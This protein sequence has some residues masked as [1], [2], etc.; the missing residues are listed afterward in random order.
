[1]A[2]R[3]F[4]FVLLTSGAVSAV[5]QELYKAPAPSTHTRWASPEN[6]GAAK[7]KAGMS[8]KG[9]KGSAF[10]TLKAGEKLVLLDVKGSGIIHRMWLS[11]TIPRS[12]EQRRLIRIDMY[13]DG[14]TKPAVSAP[15]GDFFGNGLGLSVPFQN[16]LFSNPEARS[17]NFT[18]PMPYRSGARIVL[19][20]ESSSHALVWYDINFTEEKVPADALYFHAFW[21]RS[22][23]TTL[24]QDYIIL[25]EI[26]GK[27]RYIGTNVG[28]IGDPA[29]RNTWFGEGEVKIF[30][31]GDTNIPTLSGT[32]TEDYIGSGWGQGEYYNAYQGSLVSDNANDLYTFYRYHLPDPVYFHTACK[33]TLQQI[34]NTSVQHLRE[35]QKSGA[36]VIPVQVFMKGDNEDIF[37]LKGKAPEQWLLLDR[38]ELPPIQDTVYDTRS[39]G[40]NFFRSDD[41][42]ATAYFYL[43]KPS[44]ILPALPNAG[45]RIKDMEEKVWSKTKKK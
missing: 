18:I 27:G 4:L 20:N 19:T 32:G 35:L 15:I 17:Y 11:G 8:N 44:S 6:P 7:S 12:E 14:E 10:F 5:A 29:Y 30:L 1:M 34:G 3:I 39:F 13:W 43:D 23:K 2:A 42:S 25:P 36:A 16:A 40:A 33:V 26:K 24:G 41:V 28:V 21:N 45:L 38:K 31:D 22:V 37:H 9:A